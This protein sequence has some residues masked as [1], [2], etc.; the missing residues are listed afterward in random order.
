[1]VA[2]FNGSIVTFG[3]CFVWVSSAASQ[4]APAPAAAAP[5][6]TPTP[7]LAAA[8]TIDLT[9]MPGTVQRFEIPSGR[10]EVRVQNAAPGVRYTVEFRRPGGTGMTVNIPGPY[11]HDLTAKADRPECEDW[12][13]AKRA[14]FHVT[15]EAE[16]A[17]AK[18]AMLRVANGSKCRFAKLES[19][20]LVARLGLMPAPFT[21]GVPPGTA[22]QLIVE[23]LDE[24]RKP[25]A[26]WE[27]VLQGQDRPSGWSHKNEG[28]W[29]IASA[30]QDI[31]HLVNYA[32]TRKLSGP[33]VSVASL[34]PAGR[35]PAYRVRF[36]S[37]PRWK[38]LQVDVPVREHVFSVATYQPLA[39]YL[40]S[41]MGLKARPSSK[42]DPLLRSLTDLRTEVLLAENRRLSQQLASEPLDPRMHER[43]ALLLG[44][45][46]LREG[47]GTFADLRPT[48]S[49]MSAHL[50]L[51]AALRG[52]ASPSAEGALA[53]V[54]VDLLSARFAPAAAGASRL[55]ATLKDPAAAP[56]LR[57]IDLRAS[58]AWKRLPNAAQ[59]TLLERICYVHAMRA[60]VGESAALEFLERGGKEAIADWARILLASSSFSVEV[61]RR[62]G[63]NAVARELA[64]SAPVVEM[65]PTASAADVVE[66]LARSV[67]QARPRLGTGPQPVI[68]SPTFLAAA[69]AR[70]VLDAAGAEVRGLREP[71]GLEQEAGQHSDQLSALLQPL[72]LV[73]LLRIPW[74]SERGQAA[75]RAKAAAC[76]RLAE[77]LGKRPEVLVEDGW[78]QVTRNCAT[79]RDAGLL[80]GAELWL[81]P[82]VPAGTA[83]AA[84]ARLRLGNAVYEKLSPEDVAGLYALWPRNDTI[85]SVHVARSLRRRQRP[86]DIKSAWGPAWETEALPLSMLVQLAKEASNSAEVLDLRGRQCALDVTNCMKYGADLVEAERFAEAVVAYEK[87]VA[88]ARDRVA[89]SNDADWLADYYLDNGR[90][91]AALRLAANAGAVGSAAGLATQARVLERLGRLAEAEAIYNAVSEQYGSSKLDA[92][93]I[94]RHRRGEQA[95]AQKA[96]QA[97]ERIFASGLVAADIA[98]MKPLPPPWSA[99]VAL[100]LDERW[101][102]AR[103]VKAGL[104]PGDMVLA[105]DGIRITNA[106][107][108]YC[109]RSF[110]DDPTI[111][112][113]IQRA[114]QL[115]EVK[116]PFRRDKFGPP[117]KVRRGKL[118]STG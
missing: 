111:R 64:D 65:A 4:T 87:A 72:A 13:A 86:E 43:A 44:A 88:S 32:R 76:A 42:P 113:V 8:V 53:S 89:M 85:L 114:G 48:L 36:G 105:V 71:L 19:P 23:R 56:W 39:A 100:F 11:P 24:A 74:N 104:R 62:H 93:F 47:E 45:F 108:W 98:K 63:A 50:A 22:S 80:P 92:F 49:A 94:R 109:V 106:D 5:T 118:P 96:N 84:P 91:E 78:A 110:S 59:A 33:S 69:A 97:L 83:Y 99:D 31:A 7:A 26:R 41:Q 107:Q 20:G 67:N 34:P 21:V 15:K 46:A 116:A 55:E 115:I 103:Y 81:E 38:A 54:L 3:L 75:L 57:A 10:I 37:D 14:Y 28:E 2:Q 60:A 51:A 27:A 58:R 1:M 68:A 9:K 40:L 30:V 82:P 66:A 52:N 117:A 112:L 95:Y 90:T 61:A 16:A 18:D 17:A 79:E 6:P 35:L 12:I 101:M 77:L 73:D 29:L 70:H 25:V 102:T